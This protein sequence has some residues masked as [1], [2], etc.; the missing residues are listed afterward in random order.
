MV[1]KCLDKLDQVI[2]MNREK[3]DKALIVVQ[4]TNKCLENIQ[5]LIKTEWE[6]RIQIQ[7]KVKLKFLDL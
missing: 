5:T 4:L 3:E 6:F 2:L 1:F 7:K